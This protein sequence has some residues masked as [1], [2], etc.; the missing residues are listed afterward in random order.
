MSP[1]GAIL[2]ILVL[3]ATTWGIILGGSHLAVNYQHPKD[4]A[5]VGTIPCASPG[6]P[7]CYSIPDTMGGMPAHEVQ[8]IALNNI[9][10]GQAET[11]NQNCQSVKSVTDDA[12]HDMVC[13]PQKS[14]DYSTCWGTSGPPPFL[15][16]GGCY[17]TPAA[18]MDRYRRCLIVYDTGCWTPGPADPS[19]CH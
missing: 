18:T 13:H 14:K 9:R 19:N 5:F 3:S 1:G 17:G 6:N 12:H 8:D 2:Y 10:E 11:L 4:S 16:I 7:A 15:C